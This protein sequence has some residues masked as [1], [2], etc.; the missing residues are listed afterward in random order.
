M[1]RHYGMFEFREGVSA[2]EIGACFTAMRGMVGEIPG[3]LGMEHG[4]YESPEGL[5]GGYTHGF[6]MTFDGP[7]SRDA[8]L[9]HPVHERVKELVVP[10]LERVVVF[11]FNVGA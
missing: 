10:K 3:L 2:S 11:D 9:P 1:T 7:A 5:N 6:I 4:P 8:Y